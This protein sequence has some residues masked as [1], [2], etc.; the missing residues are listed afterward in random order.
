MLTN[1]LHGEEI[2]LDASEKV[3]KLV[4]VLEADSTD[5]EKLFQVWKTTVIAHKLLSCI[6]V[7]MG[8]DSSFRYLK[9][10]FTVCA[11]S[12]KHNGKF[13]K[14]FQM[15]QGVSSHRARG[16]STCV[17]VKVTLGSGLG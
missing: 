1:L 10:L 8:Y 6:E 16:W 9:Q 3:H 12:F 15:Y 4:V 5:R 2:S 11:I 17:K 7:S 14:P 13:M